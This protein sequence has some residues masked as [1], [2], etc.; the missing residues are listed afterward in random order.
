MKII[1]KVKDLISSNK[2]VQEVP[3]QTDNSIKP[4]QGDEEITQDKSVSFNLTDLGVS[5]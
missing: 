1:K 4:E 3:E 2:I 5:K